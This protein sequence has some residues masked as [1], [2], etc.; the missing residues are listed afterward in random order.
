MGKAHK[1]GIK[2]QKDRSPAT[3]I[4]ACALFL[5]AGL[6]IGYYFGRQSSEPAVSVAGTQAPQANPVVFAQDEAALKGIIGSDPKNLDA[7]I[8]LGNLYY[9]HG[10]YSDAIQ[11]YGKALE[12]NPNNVNVRTDRG[13]SYWNLGQAD[14]AIAEFQKSLEINPSHT[15]TLYNLGVVYLNGKNDPQAAKRAWEILLAT[16]PNYPNRAKLQQDIASLSDQPAGMQPGTPPAQAG[17]SS[18]EDLLQRMK[19]TK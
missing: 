10:R 14:P 19:S 3:M 9:D 2:E 5:A 17:G 4:L 12:I 16:N 8:Q 6:G 15:Q 11:W 1:L 7:L 13:T 18:M